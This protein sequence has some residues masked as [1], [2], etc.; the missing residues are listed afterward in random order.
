MLQLEYGFTRICKI[1]SSK[2]HL[3]TRLDIL[4]G[5]SLLSEIPIVKNKIKFIKIQIKKWNIFGIS[6]LEI[7]LKSKS[8]VHLEN[9]MTEKSGLIDHHDWMIRFI[10]YLKSE[11]PAIKY[12][13]ICLVFRFQAWPLTC[14]WTLVAVG[15]NWASRRF[16]LL[17]FRPSSR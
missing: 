14:T 1:Y 13:R 11:F 5:I 10:H 8:F 16:H 4:S 9:L 6:T 7:F 3:T 17:R 2:R 15:T 12:N